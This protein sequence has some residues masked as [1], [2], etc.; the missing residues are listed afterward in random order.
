MA[1]VDHFAILREVNV[2]T[3]DFKKAPTSAINPPATSAAWRAERPDFGA[4]HTPR[5]GRE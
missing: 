4:T 1:E 3:P 2:D 5:G